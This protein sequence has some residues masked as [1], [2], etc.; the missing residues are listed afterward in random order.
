MCVPFITPTRSGAA[1]GG[2]S[3]G[4]EVFFGSLS[5]VAGRPLQA[6][7]HG[8]RGLALFFNFELHLPSLPSL[9]AR[10]SVV[11]AP[12]ILLP[13]MSSIAFLQLQRPYHAIPPFHIFLVNQMFLS[14]A[15]RTNAT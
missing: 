10:L 15:L 11:P 14:S 6:H 5:V 4:F 13:A 12:P 9:R 3:H 8:A 1:A 7:T 2:L